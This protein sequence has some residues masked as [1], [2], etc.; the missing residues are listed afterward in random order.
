MHSTVESPRPEDLGTRE[1]VQVGGCSGNASTQMSTHPPETMNV[2]F[3]IFITLLST[4]RDA[5]QWSMEGSHLLSSPPFGK[6]ENLAPGGPS[7]SAELQELVRHTEL[8]DISHKVLVKRAG[9]ESKQILRFN[10]LQYIY[11][12]AVTSDELWL[13]LCDHLFNLVPKATRCRIWDLRVVLKLRSG[14][15]ILYGCYLASTVT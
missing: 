4:Q 12:R 15:P 14:R 1:D 8:N 10:L 11:A 9:P 6:W 2:R 3:S 5:S 7:E 13:Y